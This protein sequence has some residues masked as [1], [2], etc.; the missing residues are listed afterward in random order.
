MTVGEFKARDKEWFE[1]GLRLTELAVDD[2]EFAAVWR[3]GSGAQRWLSAT[4]S[5]L[6]AKDKELLVGDLRMSS[7]EIFDGDLPSEGGG[8][9]WPWDSFP[10][11][12]GG[13]Q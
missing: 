2:G 11:P 6:D 10:D 1:K 8:S 12:D 3:P 7:L 4:Y 5:P 13:F 9:W